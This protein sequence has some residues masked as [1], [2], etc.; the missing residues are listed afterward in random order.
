LAY[1]FVNIVDGGSQKDVFGRIETTTELLLILKSAFVL[2][3][4]GVLNA[5]TVIDVLG[6]VTRNVVRLELN[7]RIIALDVDQAQLVRDRSSDV[8]VLPDL[9][10]IAEQFEDG[11]RIVRRQMSVR[12]AVAVAR[13]SEFDDRR[14]HFNCVIEFADFL[15]KLI[16]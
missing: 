16:W 4:N 1:P 2:V 8:L 12:M 9:K 7:F 15:F 5:R 3:Q 13:G 6:K 10:G 14:I 11:Q